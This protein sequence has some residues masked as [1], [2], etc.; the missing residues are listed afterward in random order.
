MDDGEA[1]PDL[2][3][4]QVSAAR[5]RAATALEAAPMSL[6]SILSKSKATPAADDGKKKSQAKD[7]PLPLDQIIATGMHSTV[8][9]S[10]RENASVVGQQQAG[11]VE[12]GNITSVNS[13]SKPMGVTSDNSKDVIK[14][15][16]ARIKIV[17]R[18]SAKLK[19]D[20]DQSH[21]VAMARMEEEIADLKSDNVRLHADLDMATTLLNQSQQAAHT[22]DQEEPNTA[23]PK[24]NAE[25]ESNATVP[26]FNASTLS[27]TT[28]VFDDMQPSKS[29][30]NK[31]ISHA[32]SARTK[33]KHKAKHG[34][35]V[36]S[37][38]SE[39]SHSAE[40]SFW[41]ISLAPDEGSPTVLLG[42]RNYSG[43]GA[44]TDDE[45]ALANVSLA[46]G[47]GFSVAF[48]ASWHQI[49]PFS[50]IL[51][52][53]DGTK[54]VLRV[55]STED[56]GTLSFSVH[57][58]HDDGHNCQH[59]AS[60]DVNGAIVANATS[61]YLCSVSPEGK[62]QVYKDGRIVGR[63]K[64]DGT[65]AMPG[66]PGG[67][68]V[69]AAEARLYVARRTWMQRGKGVPPFEGFLGDICLWSR[70]VQPANA[71]SCIVHQPAILSR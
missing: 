6:N 37:R 69:P 55:T 24:S 31:N 58:C 29:V 22:S 30:R 61:R 70:E 38:Q 18:Q 13:K 11:M 34:V 26:Y 21:Q 53:S 65:Y 19:K 23:V 52:L 67:L 43:V 56:A 39:T 45:E 14:D 66:Q 36:S 35:E 48:T 8:S 9:L 68:R 20:G 4:I 40:A 63:L 17:E 1:S 16:K 28:A 49:H 10:T 46:E 3:L 2:S 64:P 25:A 71:A 12:Q 57:R 32:R 59:F 5:M 50:R 41:K 44:E 27:N 51:S 42:G 60:V 15:L 62:M 7:P 54:D 33:A 47:G